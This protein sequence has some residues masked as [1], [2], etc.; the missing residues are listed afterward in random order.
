MNDI[1]KEIITILFAAASESTTACLL[2]FTICYPLAQCKI[3]GPVFSFYVCNMD[4]HNAFCQV[5]FIGCNAIK[6]FMCNT[7]WT[8]QSK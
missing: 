2:F 5:M 1:E 7:T 3:L 6:F 8:K 4:K